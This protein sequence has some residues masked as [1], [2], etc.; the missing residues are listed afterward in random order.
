MKAPY[1]IAGMGFKHEGSLETASKMIEAAARSGADAVKFQ[2]YQ[3]EDIALPNSEHFEAI[4]HGVLTESDHM[5][6]VACSRDMDVDF[7]STP[8]SLEAVDQLD[9]MVKA[10]KIASMDCCNLD[11]LEKVAS[12]G[13]P[14]FLST[15]MASL[16]DIRSSVN[17][18]VSKG[19]K[20][21]TIMH[22]MSLYPAPREEANL[23]FIKEL[24]HSF[25]WP[26]GYSDHVIGA[27]ACIAAFLL[28]AEV[29]ETHFT[30]DDGLEGADHYHS[31][32]PATLK[33]LIETLGH[34]SEMIGDSQIKDRCDAKF[35]CDYRRGLYFSKEL[36]I[37]HVLQREDLY[38][39]R[40]EHDPSLASLKD[41]IGKRLTSKVM[42]YSP[43]EL[44]QLK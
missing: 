6:L 44:N 10:F 7:L 31:L 18:L 29:I 15:G 41:V 22:C 36:N 43:L 2:T 26:V 34:Y 30:L 35:K 27:D 28:G 17:F 38:F 21:L 23:S 20:T 13:K 5:E 4:G 32:T 24:Q 1:I 25:E 16:A 9:S 8:F 42:P 3:A 33:D 40:P 11:L 39:C 37:G 19:C 12:K 14:I